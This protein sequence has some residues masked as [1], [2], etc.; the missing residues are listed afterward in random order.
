MLSFK[1]FLSEL[2]AFME[3]I[4]SLKLPDSQIS[5]RIDVV[6]GDKIRG[7]G[8]LGAATFGRSLR[9]EGTVIS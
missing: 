6:T 3:L 4:S 7:T 9:P 5:L 8:L 2:I 1:D